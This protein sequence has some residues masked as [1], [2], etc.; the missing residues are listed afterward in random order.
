MSCTTCHGRDGREKHENPKSDCVLPKPGVQNTNELAW[1]I[2]IL[3]VSV[4]IWGVTRGASCHNRRTVIVTQCLMKFV[5]QTHFC[6]PWDPH[7]ENCRRFRG[8]LGQDAKFVVA[9]D[10]KARSQRWRAQI[11]WDF[12]HWLDQLL[13]FYGTDL[14]QL[15]M[16]LSVRSHASNMESMKTRNA[17]LP[18][19]TSYKWISLQIRAPI[20]RGLDLSVAMSESLRIFF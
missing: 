13:Y 4:A 18:V 16:T 14:T 5:V 8:F 10:Y 3:A 15:W 17:K 12:L 7:F 20:F 19:R 6:S 9:S 1:R 11:N 2:W